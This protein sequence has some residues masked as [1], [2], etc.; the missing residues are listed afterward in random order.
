[1]KSIEIPKT[2]CNI[3]I[4]QDMYFEVR[5]RG[6][7]LSSFVNDALFGFF[8]I[9]DRLSSQ[10][11]VKLRERLEELRIA[12]NGIT[13]EELVIESKLSNIERDKE[14][15]MK[16]LQERE[17]NKRWVCSVCLVMSPPVR[18]LNYVNV[19]KC[20]NCNLGK[21]TDSKT[22]FEYIKD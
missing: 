3:T 6:M 10:P 2:R 4:D 18:S 17:N 7:N 19:P 9:E 8:K 21:I 14:V 5:R 11:E 15:K 13:T 22:T 16:E 12:R 1:M 20:L